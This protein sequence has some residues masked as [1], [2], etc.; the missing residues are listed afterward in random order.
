MRAFSL[1]TLAES[2]RLALADLRG[3]CLAPPQGSRFFPFD[4]QNFRNVTASGVGG[5]CYEVNAPPHTGNPGSAT[6]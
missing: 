1:C 6:D 4:I 2:M 3:A 5:P